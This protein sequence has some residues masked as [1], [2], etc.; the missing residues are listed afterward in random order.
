MSFFVGESKNYTTTVI[1]EI[2][3]EKYAA[4]AFWITFVLIHVVNAEN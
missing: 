1:S 2:T 4:N 3:K